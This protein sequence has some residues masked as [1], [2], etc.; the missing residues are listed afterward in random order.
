VTRRAT[1]PAPAPSGPLAARIRRSPWSRAAALGLVVAALAGTAYALPLQDLARS[2]ARFGP[3]PAVALAVGLLL[4]LVPRTAVSLVFGAL[5]GALAGSACALIAALVA[6]SVAFAA[7]RWLAREAVADRLRGRAA[8][9]DSWLSRRGLLAVVV[10]RLV[11]IAPYG[12]VSYLYG[13]TGVRTRHYLLGTFIGA[14]PSAVTWAG[15]GAAVIDRGQLGVLTIVP[16]AAG[17]V[18][19]V[20][21]AAWWRSSMRRDAAAGAG[22]GAGPEPRPQPEARAR[23]AVRPPR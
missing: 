14:T 10:V 20:C 6:A 21:A 15:I 5:F 18:V 11:P 9:F 19:T 23:S 4:A 22:A 17:L 7:A 8:R 13:S 3:V 12:L 2:A 16:A 1:P